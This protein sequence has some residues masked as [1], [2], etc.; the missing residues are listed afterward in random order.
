MDIESFVS[1]IDDLFDGPIA[2]GRPKDARFA[3]LAADVAGFT[4]AAELAVL[5][6]AARHLPEGEAYLEVGT[7]KGRSLCGVLVDAPSRRYVAVEDFSEFGMHTADARRELELALGRHSGGHDVVV[8]DGDAF[9][10][11]A[12]RR[13]VGQPVG[14][15][16]YDGA[17][18]GLAHYLAL[19]V[20]EPLL[21][22]ESVVLVDDATW[23]M[24]AS[25]TRRYVASHPG[26]RIVRDIRAASDHDARWANGLMILEFRRSPGTPR[27]MG[28]DVVWRR[29]WQVAVRGPSTRLIRRLLRR[30]PALVP[31]A[32][33][34]VRKGPRQVAE[35]LTPRPG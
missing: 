28:R 10:L 26:W 8:Y 29:Q 30:F 5:N 1:D 12:D 33:R 16:F 32:K 24:V 17:H 14:A 9:R 27:P 23:P 6:L 31:L 7:F 11:M 15:Y 2:D 22:D 4:T 34:L 13:L 20:V 3:A 21:A 19:G 18:T 25:A 35:D